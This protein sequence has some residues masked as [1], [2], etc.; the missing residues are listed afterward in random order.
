MTYSK[1]IQ[2]IS[3]C[4]NNP[5]G[6]NSEAHPNEITVV[7]YEGDDV[8]ITNGND[9]VPETINPPASSYTS[10]NEYSSGGSIPNPA[11]NAV[12]DS[13]GWRLQNNN[14]LIS[15]ANFYYGNAVYLQV[16]LGIA[17][18]IQGFGS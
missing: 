7:V 15:T 9:Q 4:A 13:T 5:Q 1:A 3:L 6:C 8:V 11:A 10:N 18:T 16:D 14:W 12:L 2:A 17:Y